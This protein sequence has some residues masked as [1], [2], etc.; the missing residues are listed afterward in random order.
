MLGDKRS[1][2]LTTKLV[3]NNKYNHV[4]M[5]YSNYLNLC[6]K[7]MPFDKKDQLIW[8]IK[9]LQQS[10]QYIHQTYYRTKL[11]HP[12]ELFLCCYFSGCEEGK[13]HIWTH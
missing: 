13:L 10:M 4:N 1:A 9:K 3:A 5:I 12:S 11:T 7:F 6:C 2:N 8:T